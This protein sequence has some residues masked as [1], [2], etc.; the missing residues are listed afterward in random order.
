M[1][2]THELKPRHFAALCNIPAGPANQGVRP[3]EVAH[4]LGKSCCAMQRIM[5]DLREWGYAVV[6]ERTRKH[7]LTPAGRAALAQ[8]EEGSH[9]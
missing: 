5:F 8:K 9:G 1:S 3:A 4:I 6:D 7:A 2:E